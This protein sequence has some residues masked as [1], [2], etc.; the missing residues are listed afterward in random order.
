MPIEWRFL[1]KHVVMSKEKGISGYTMF[2]NDPY[3]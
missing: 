1:A 2:C 3:I